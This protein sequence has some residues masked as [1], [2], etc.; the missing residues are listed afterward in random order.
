MKT[1]DYNITDREEFFDLA[2]AE[3]GELHSTEARLNNSV[4][5]L[6]S[7]VHKIQNNDLI[8][9][10]RKKDP[11][12]ASTIAVGRAGP[13]EYMKKPPEILQYIIPAK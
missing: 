1:K 9:L 5:Q 6:Y 10:P 11:S 12:M 8:I 7:F 3:E 2:K 4:G 13:Y